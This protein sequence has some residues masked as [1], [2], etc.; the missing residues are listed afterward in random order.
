[1]DFNIESLGIENQLN[2]KMEQFELFSKKT[3][4]L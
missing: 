4:T 3:N 1:M 2:K